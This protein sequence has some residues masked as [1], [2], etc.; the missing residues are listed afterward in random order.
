MSRER[1][2]DC[3]LL[4]HYREGTKMGLH[5]DNDEADF[6][7]PV[8]SI[9]LGDEALF[10]MGNHDRGG[11]TESV[12][13]TSGDVVVMGGDARLRYHGIDRIKFGSSKLLS[14]GGRLN[15]TCRVVD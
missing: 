9:S 15:L 3:C 14:Q 6:Y 10:R 11:K 13:L 4:N 5:Q 2:P 8:L 1:A 7:W 12:W